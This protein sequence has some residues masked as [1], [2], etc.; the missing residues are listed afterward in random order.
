MAIFSHPD[1]AEIWA[2]GS[3][4][5]WNSL[6]GISTIVC[7]STDKMREQEGTTGTRVLDQNVLL[8]SRL[9][10]VRYAEGFI[11]VPI[12]GKLANLTLF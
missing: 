6:G 12:L 8:G 11:Q 2:G 4:A 1:D 5:K 7:F 9:S 3:I 10:N